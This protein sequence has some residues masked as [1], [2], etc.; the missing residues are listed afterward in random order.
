MREY[1]ANISDALNFKI[2]LFAKEKSEQE[3]RRVK[4]FNAQQRRLKA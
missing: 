3:N 4:L 1:S 2:R